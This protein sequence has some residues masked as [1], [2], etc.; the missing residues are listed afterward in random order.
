MTDS[1]ISVKIWRSFVETWK[2][3]KGA[4]DSNLASMGISSTTY[5]MLRHLIEDGPMPMAEIASL[6]I[7]TPGWITG[8]VD[9]LEERGLVERIR[10]KQDRR[11]I[12]IQVTEE[13]ITLYKK[14]SKVH[15]AFIRDCLEQLDD[16]DAI[17]LLENMEKLRSTVETRKKAIKNKLH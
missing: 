12:D 10:N 15:M 11:I 4:V 13:G 1:D 8:L 9:S 3:W 14:A 6:L 7:V 5:S 16:K 2:T 17:S